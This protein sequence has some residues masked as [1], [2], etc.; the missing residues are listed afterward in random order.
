MVYL[1]DEDVENILFYSGQAKRRRHQ[2]LESLQPTYAAGLRRRAHTIL[3]QW[4]TAGVPDTVWDALQREAPGIVAKY[5]LF[6]IP[7]APQS[8]E[9]SAAVIEKNVKSY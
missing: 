9:L 2:S 5:N 8:V 1:E 3:E 7:L 4:S 6:I